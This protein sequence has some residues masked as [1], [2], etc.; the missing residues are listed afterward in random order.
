[1]RGHVDIHML[2]LCDR[3]SV[4]GTVLSSSL[5]VLS[6]DE[7]GVNVVLAERDGAESL[8]VKVESTAIDL[9]R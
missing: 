2:V 3:M 6:V 9:V 5:E 8:K 4:G 1:M 7:A